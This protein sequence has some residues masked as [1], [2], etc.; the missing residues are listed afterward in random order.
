M[1][2]I[3]ID[4]EAIF[5]WLRNTFDYIVYAM[6]VFLPVYIFMGV[7]GVVTI[8]RSQ[9]RLKELLREILS[10]R[11]WIMQIRRFITELPLLVLSVAFLVFWMFTGDKM[12][13]FSGLFFLIIFIDLVSRD[14][15]LRFSVRDVLVFLYSFAAVS[16]IFFVRLIGLNVLQ[17]PI[18]VVYLIMGSIVIVYIVFGYMIFI[19]KRK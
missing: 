4:V 12:H 16:T 14:S 2:V 13:L 3:S 19:R 18:E 1:L 7:M 17:L 15:H 10:G 9:G 11:C 6:I 8:A 5:P